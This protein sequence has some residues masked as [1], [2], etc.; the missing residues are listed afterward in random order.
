MPVLQYDVQERSPWDGPAYEIHW[1][2]PDPQ[3]A[4]PVRI[5]VLG[6]ACRGALTLACAKDTS[7]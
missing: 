2:P 6:E 4:W 3:S 7:R 1:E 5:C